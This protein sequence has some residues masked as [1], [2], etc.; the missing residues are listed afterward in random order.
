VLKASP[1]W[2]TQRA[3]CTLPFS[4][5]SRWPPCSPT[6][7]T[8][9][10]HPPAQMQ[11][12]TPVIN[13][14][15]RLHPVHRCQISVVESICSMGALVSKSYMVCADAPHARVSR[16]C[17]LCHKRTLSDASV[18]SSRNPN[19][20]DACSLTLTLLWLLVPRFLCSRRSLSL[21]LSLT[22]PSLFLATQK[23]VLAS[24]VLLLALMHC[25]I[26]LRHPPWA[27]HGICTWALRHKIGNVHAPSR[28]KPSIR[29]RIP[30]GS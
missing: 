2:A 24:D 29:G 14:V 13:W 16:R 30:G 18:R 20:W 25:L 9:P 3:Q 17:W 23:Q 12:L 21:F 10:A 26:P 4:L 11:R 7:C 8:P 1:R 22:L 5:P 27:T 28:R 15:A 6:C 19:L